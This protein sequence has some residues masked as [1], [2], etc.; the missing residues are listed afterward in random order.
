MPASS[1]PFYR[2]SSF[3]QHD[4]PGTS[5]KVL[6]PKNSTSS[7]FGLSTYVEPVPDRARHIQKKSNPLYIDDIE[8]SRPKAS[9]FRTRRVVDPLAPKYLLPSASEIAV[10]Q[11]RKFIRDTLNT[12]D[13]SGKRSHTLGHRREVIKEPVEGSSPSKL[14]KDVSAVP[15]LEVKDIN[16]EYIFESRRST[17][18]LQPNYQWRDDFDKNLNRDY[19]S[20]QGSNVRQMHPTSV[21][22]PNNLS[23]GIKDI[24]GTQANSYYAR[25]HFVDVPPLRPRNGGNS[26]IT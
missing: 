13:I 5:P 10:D 25:S 16:K 11:G 26:A 7:N 8:G 14:T 4:I 23:L 19:G 2:E 12:Q 3:L 21:N 15:R 9:E 1:K 17:N 24:E 6:I 20:I 22:R 18:P